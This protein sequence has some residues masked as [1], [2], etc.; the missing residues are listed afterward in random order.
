MCGTIWYLRIMTW[1]RYVRATIRCPGF[2]LLAGRSSK[3]PS[4][5]WGPGG[6]DLRMHGV[7]LLVR[8]SGTY[9]DGDGRR[10]AVQAGA[11][12][13]LF[14]GLRHEYGPGPGEIWEE[15]FLD[16]DGDLPR[17]LERQGRLDRRHPVRRPETAA[18]AALRQLIDEVESGRLSD[19]HEAQWRLHG[20]LLAL[21]RWDAGGDDGRLDRARQVLAADPQRQLDLRAA[22]DAAEM[23]WEL[24]RKRFRERFGLPPARYRLHVRCEAAAQALLA[25]EEPVEEVARMLGFCDGAHLRRHFRRVLG[26]SPEAFRRLHRPG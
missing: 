3:S 23:G 19:P 1:P 9:H 6:R 21:A 26:Q 11:L 17:L 22:A 16:C 10:E 15:A 24:F 20:V 5:T 7:L 13:L 14:P 25:G 18:V 4:H 2:T 12:F 8:G